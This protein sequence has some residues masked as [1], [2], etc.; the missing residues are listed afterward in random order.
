VAPFNWAHNP[1]VAGSNPAP[2]TNISN[3]RQ[4]DLRNALR[5]PSGAATCCWTA[6]DQ[7]IT[8]VEFLFVEELAVPTLPFPGVEMFL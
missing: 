2:A 6:H 8:D 4:P 3:R 5:Q 1:K 7:P